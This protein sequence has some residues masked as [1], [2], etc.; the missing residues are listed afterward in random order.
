MNLIDDYIIGFPEEVQKKLMEIRKVIR[1]TAPMA[2]EKIS[3][4]MPT[5]YF[6]GN[7]VHFAAFSK[8]IGLYPGPSGVAAFKEELVGYKS[9]K[10][11][12]QFPLDE[13]LPLG[14][15]RR[16]VQFRVAE[17]IKK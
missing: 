8:H 7:L 12:I 10:G 16:I 4:R 5:F 9:S 1:E 13:D 6:K 17:N 14:L 3:Y 11:A 2:E 15:I